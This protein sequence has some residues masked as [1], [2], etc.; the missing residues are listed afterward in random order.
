MAK[1]FRNQRVT[2]TSVTQASTDIWLLQFTFPE[3]HEFLF[4]PGQFINVGHSSVLKDD[5]KTILKRAF[6]IASPPFFETTL[7]LCIKR[8]EKGKL[9]PVL[10]ALS[11][12]KTLDIDGP[13]GLFTLRENAAEYLFIAGGS[14]IAPFASMIR[15]LLH[16]GITVPITLI[17]SIRKPNDY[18]Y[19]EAFE[20][21]A[22]LHKNFSIVVTCTRVE[23]LDHWEG[24]TGRISSEILTAHIHNPSL[25]LSYLCGPQSFVDSMRAILAQ[26]GMKKE[27]ILFERWG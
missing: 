24:Q 21:L 2:I 23:E 12:G 6:S 5:G 18:C 10:T 22:Q 7:E 25:A 20:K 9:S 26:M 1:L 3:I 16:Q 11:P 17:Y 4:V 8:E 13:F 14:G 15:H 27:Q 19:C